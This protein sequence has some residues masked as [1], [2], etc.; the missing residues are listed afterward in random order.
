MPVATRGGLLGAGLEADAVTR[1]GRRGGASPAPWAVLLAAV[2]GIWLLP[3]A[4]AL[5]LEGQQPGGAGGNAAM[6]RATFVVRITDTGFIPQNLA[7]NVGD[8]VTWTNV[9]PNMN[10]T[11][12]SRNNPPFWDSGILVPGQSFSHTFL[13]PG[14]FGYISTIDV[15]GGTIVVSAAPTAPT[16]TSVLRVNGI[17][18]FPFSY[19]ITATGAT[20]ITFT[21]TNLP[22][23]LS[24]ASP[25]LSGTPPAAGTYTA[26]LQATNA[27][28]ADNQTLTITISPAPGTN[29][30]AMPVFSPAPG[31]YT[32]AQSVAISCATPGSTIFFTVD[33][34]VPTRFSTVYSAPINVSAN[35]TLQAF[36]TATGMTDG[37]VAVGTYTISSSGG[38]FSGSG[39]TTFMYGNT[40]LHV[41]GGGADIIPI[42][43]QDVGGG[44]PPATVTFDP[45]QTYLPVSSNPNQVYQYTVIWNFGDNAGTVLGG[46]AGSTPD[47][48]LALV[49]HTYVNEGAYTVT[50]QIN[51][52][53][54]N[55][56]LLPNETTPAKAKGPSAR[57]TGQVHT[58]TVNFPPTAQLTAVG[59][60]A[61]GTLPYVLQVTPGASFDEDGYIVWAAMDWGDGSFGQVTPLPPNRPNAVMSHSYVTP[62]I[63]R[64]TLSVIDNGRLT[65]A[66]LPPKPEPRDARAALNVYVQA[67]LLNAAANAALLDPKYNPQLKQTAIFVQVPGNM[68]ITTGQFQVDFK[69]ASADSFTL[70]LRTN[71]SPDSVANA[72]VQLTLG[73]GPTP[74]SLSNFTLDK[75]GSYTNQALGLTF[76]FAG[77]KAALRIKFSRAN[78]AAAFGLVDGTAVNANVDVPVKVVINNSLILATTARF[79]YNAKAGRKGNGRNGRS[80]PNGN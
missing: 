51:I 52:T 21:A 22:A 33:G 72:A 45:T 63:Y 23:W 13:A 25:T 15:F 44:T 2:W 55:Q 17:A 42:F 36:A 46:A 32:S 30:V 49:S 64:V 75:R 11:T 27:L 57:T 7:I 47:Q 8:T 76:A 12:T 24:F 39:I 28:G 3:N 67:T 6:G 43:T 78:L 68:V 65:Q 34:T 80:Y 70:Q 40:V 77:K 4:A 56:F 74:V 35:I 18:G 73:S 38:S 14:T 37:P 5:A 1:A 54:V 19:T 16:I 20:P 41:G 26:S 58:A 66:Q 71:L 69:R 60:A 48:V 59:S 31:T 29:N 61:S 10:H 9:S 79:V 62:G 53:V 50:L